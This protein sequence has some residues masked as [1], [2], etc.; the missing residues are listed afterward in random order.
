MANT[1][2]NYYSSYKEGWEINYFISTAME[3]GVEFGAWASQ[4]MSATFNKKGFKPKKKEGDV[5]N[6]NKR[7]IS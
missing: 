5:R 6:N 2:S 3:N 7:N 4:A 1:E